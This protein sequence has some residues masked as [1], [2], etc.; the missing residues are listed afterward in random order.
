MKDISDHSLTCVKVVLGTKSFEQIWI[1]YGT[2]LLHE[3]GAIG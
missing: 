2:A 3:C 1:D